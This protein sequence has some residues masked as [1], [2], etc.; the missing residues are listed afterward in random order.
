[1]FSIKLIALSN[2]YIINGLLSIFMLISQSVYAVPVPVGVPLTQEK[3]N[4]IKENSKKPDP[5]TYL[6]KGYIQPHLDKFVPTASRVVLLNAYCKYGVG[7]PDHTEFVSTKADVDMLVGK[8]SAVIA[9]ELG[10]PEAQLKDSDLVRINFDTSNALNKNRLK[11]PSGNEFGANEQWLPGGKLPTG[12]LEAVINTLNLV[13]GTDYTV[14]FL[15]KTGVV[16]CP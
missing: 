14:S 1:M 8:T 7:K 16:V 11:M 6:D 10:I 4:E 3:F 2:K 15:N 5:T 13:K 9:A 12:K